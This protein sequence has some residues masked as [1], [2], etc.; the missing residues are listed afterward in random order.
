MTSESHKR[1]GCP[2]GTNTADS[3]AC[4]RSSA[5]QAIVF[6]VLLVF[7]CALACW[8]LSHW[9]ADWRNPALSKWSRV[10]VGDKEARVRAL[11]GKPVFDWSQET[12]PAEYRISGY[13]WPERGINGKVLI[14][15]EADLIL[16]IWLDE[17]GAVE[18]MFTGAS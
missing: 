13:R 9:K 8:Y 12:A 2:V 5:K 18:E 16:Y 14:Y 10:H 6:L 1:R 4:S 11:L 15:M 3:T 17:S 7:A